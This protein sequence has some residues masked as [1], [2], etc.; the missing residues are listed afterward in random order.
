VT[1]RLL[2]GDELARGIREEASRD[3]SVL[4][5]KLGRAPVLVAIEAAREG[6]TRVFGKA[7][8]AAAREIGIRARHVRVDPASGE[9]GFAAAL[10][11]AS[12]DPAIDAITIER[13][14]PAS[15][16]V[17]GLQELIAPEKDIEGLH[18]VNMGR[19][20]SGAPVRFV[21]PAA[22]AAL[23]LL[24]AS[25]LALE[26][27]QVAVVGAGFG[28]GRP[29][30]LLLLDAKATVEVCHIATRDLASR[31]RTADALVV[32]AGSPGLIRASMI[33]P[34]AV[35]IDVGTTVVHD[36]TTGERCTRGDVHEDVASVATAV[37][38]VPGGVGPLTV[39]LLLRNALRAASRLHE[40]SEKAHG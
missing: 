21:P 4:T 20:V 27:A 24:R 1:A 10:R 12:A 13:P 15:W 9:A 18:P 28:V 14:L 32:C 25:G 17:V 29:V 8:R 5:S 26:G 23:V 38:P 35:V 7:K 19:L 2:P 31:T 40:L 11:A 33:K 3:A 37:T 36:P 16:D 30:A 6:A 34:G 39:A 22:E